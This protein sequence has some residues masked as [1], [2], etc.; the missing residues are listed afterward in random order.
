[1]IIRCHHTARDFPL[2]V[3]DIEFDFEGKTGVRPNALYL[4]NKEWATFVEFRD[5]YAPHRAHLQV[6]RHTVPLQKEMELMRVIE[7]PE[8]L[9]R[10]ETTEIP[11]FRGLFVFHV[12]SP[13]HFA[14][15]LV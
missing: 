13:Q 14:V 12:D 9:E 1:M 3:R 11:V 2:D 15:G 5:T 7:N 10:L 4:G 6:Q 8:P